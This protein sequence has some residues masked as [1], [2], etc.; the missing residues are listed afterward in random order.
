MPP[1]S[2]VAVLSVSLD[3]QIATSGTPDVPGT[4]GATLGDPVE[5]QRRYAEHLRALH[6]VVKTGRRAG[7]PSGHGAVT[8]APNAWAYPTRSRSRYAF[9][10]DAAPDS[11][12]SPLRADAWWLRLDEAALERKLGAAQAYPEMREEVA[13]ALERF[14]RHAFAVECLR[15]AATR[16]MIA[17]SSSPGS[18]RSRDQA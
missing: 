9:V 17:R 15:P 3:S 18:T 16:S 11:C 6:V 14:G 13:A 10:L 5:R 7:A 12:P 1:S 2:A 8:L 4:G